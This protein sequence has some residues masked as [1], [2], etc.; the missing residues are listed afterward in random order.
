MDNISYFKN[1]NLW[2]S[3]QCN[4]D[5]LVRILINFLNNK[6]QSIN[7]TDVLE[8]IPAITTTKIANVD[9]ENRIKDKMDILWSFQR[10]L[11]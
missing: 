7:L 8:R 3:R 11:R 10:K 6:S 2:V 5:E 9:V 4:E 1:N